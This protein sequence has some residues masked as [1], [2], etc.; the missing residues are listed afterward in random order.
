MKTNDKHYDRGVDLIAEAVASMLY[1]SEELAECL[2]PD[3]VLEFEAL[4]DAAL[5]QGAER[6]IIGYAEQEEEYGLAAED[7]VTYE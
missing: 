4:R 2:E 3:E 6:P 7:S 5:S 1:S